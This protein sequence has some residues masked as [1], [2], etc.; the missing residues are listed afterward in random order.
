MT[1]P[2]GDYFACRMKDPGYAAAYQVLGPEYQAERERIR[3]RI[4]QED[5]I[6]HAFKR[7]M[8][9]LEAHPDLVQVLN[10]LKQVRDQE[11]LLMYLGPVRQLRD[12]RAGFQI[13]SDADYNSNFVST[14]VTYH[15][16]VS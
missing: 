8:E 10:W 5:S 9:Y 2:I 3:A 4:Q 16:N 13:S 7:V 12:A 15:V 1:K 6:Q 14:E 11:A